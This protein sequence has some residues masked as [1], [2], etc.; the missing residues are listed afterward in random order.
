MN[1]FDLRVWREGEG[2]TQSEAADRL[3]VGRRTIARAESEPE[4]G[5]SGKLA[6]AVAMDRL[7]R[8]PADGSK[9]AARAVVAIPV[10]PCEYPKIIRQ[11]GKAEPIGD[12]FHI[13]RDDKGQLFGKTAAECKAIRLHLGDAEGRTSGVPLVAMRPDWLHLRSGMQ[14]NAAIPEPIDRPCGA[15]AGG[16]GR[17]TRSG[18]VYDYETAHRM[19]SPY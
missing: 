3:D 13:W 7:A 16:R 11:P 2:L 12:G 8:V 19:R 4:A 18:V 17:M 14:L 10:L 6:D 5:V 9:P 1:G 15:W